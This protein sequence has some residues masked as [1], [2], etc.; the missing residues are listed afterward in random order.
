MCVCVCVC[1][2]ARARVPVRVRVH[3]R[4]RV[5]ACVRA[6]VCARV[7]V[8]V[9][10]CARGVAGNSLTW[11]CRSPVPMQREACAVFTAVSG[12][13]AFSLERVAQTLPVQHLRGRRAL[14]LPLRL[15]LDLGLGRVRVLTRP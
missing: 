8:C 9:C 5:R 15:G 14:S 13:E 6:C 7:C 12:S 10:V 2:R 1:V 11:H 4:V 3:V